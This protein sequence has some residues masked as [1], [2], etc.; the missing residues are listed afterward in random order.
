[1]ILLNKN[2]KAIAKNNPLSTELVN[3]DIALTVDIGGVNL[4]DPKEFLNARLVDGDGNP[5]A[6]SGSGSAS[7]TD[8]VDIIEI[9]P[10]TPIRDTNAKTVPL[11]DLKKYKRY[12]IQVSNYCNQDVKV[13]PWNTAPAVLEDNT[14]GIFST[15]A[16]ADDSYSWQAPKKDPNSSGIFFLNILEPKSNGAGTKKVK[17]YER[18]FD[19]VYS[20]SGTSMVLAYKAVTAPTDGSLTIRFIG[21]KR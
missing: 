17:A 9:L 6:F 21:F 2:R 5:I 19:S 12:V 1:M 4:N 10:S 20:V 14:V 15:T 18:L 8:A 7:E 11:P 13:V 3:S 16:T